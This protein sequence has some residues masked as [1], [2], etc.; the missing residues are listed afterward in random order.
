MSLLGRVL[1]LF[2]PSYKGRKNQGLNVKSDPT[3]P[4]LVERTKGKLQR[5]QEDY[6]SYAQEGYEKNVVSKTCIERNTRAMAGVPVLLKSGYGKTA[7]DIDDVK[8]PLITLLRRPNP[9]Q[10]G[11]CFWENFLAYYFLR[12]NTYLIGN[13]PKD[14]PD[15]PPTEL[16]TPRP[17]RMFPVPGEHG[18]PSEYVFKMDEMKRRFPVNWVDGSSQVMHWKT[19]NPLNDWLGMPPIKAASMNVDCNN[20]ANEWNMNVLQNSGR[21]SGAFVYAPTGN[22]APPSMGRTKK[23][24]LIKDLEDEIM[25]PKNAKRPLILDGGLDWREMAMNAVELD[26]LEGKTDAARMICLAYG[27]P[28]LLLC[29]PGDNTYKNYEEARLAYYEDTILPMHDLWMEHL[30]AWLVPRFGDDLRLVA[31]RHAISAL[32][33]RT[34]EKFAIVN[35]ANFLT[36]NE[37]RA[38][39]NYEPLAVPEADEVWLPST[40]MPMSQQLSM[41]E[42]KVQGAQASAQGAGEQDPPSPGDGGKQKPNGKH[43]DQELELKLERQSLTLKK[44]IDDLVGRM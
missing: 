11:T 40:L 36:H 3:G 17:D 12:G 34:T 1:D 14:E 19:F 10:T 30:N 23:E 26:W 25:Q 18:C 43:I 37:K 33:P 13:G 21:P 31:D 8:H 7:T 35:A 5:M 42:A 22:T 39:L 29:I 32:T 15:A 38:A 6:K 27:V 20:S 44:Q 41:G 28:S 9:F 4:I 24:E 2:E 16:Y